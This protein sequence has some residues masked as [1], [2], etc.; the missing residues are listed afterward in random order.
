MSAAFEAAVTLLTRLLLL[1]LLV[2]LGV[3]V[4]DLRGREEA[5]MNLPTVTASPPAAR[6][7][8]RPSPSPSPVAP[9]PAPSVRSSE[10]TAVVQGAGPCAQTLTSTV[11]SWARKSH[12]TI[13]CS[14]S[15][16]EGISYSL[17]T[18]RLLVAPGFPL[19]VAT[20]ARFGWDRVPQAYRNNPE[21][22]CAQVKRTWSSFVATHAPEWDVLCSGEARALP[23]RINAPQD[24]RVAGEAVFKNKTIHLFQR[25]LTLAALEETLIHE[26]GHAEASRW[27]LR[28]RRSW[29]AR[30]GSPW[31]TG[32][33]ERQSSEVWA[34]SYSRY[35]LRRPGG[36]SLVK[37]LG[38]AAVEAQLRLTGA[39]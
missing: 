7:L 25:T 36:V 24:T 23:G 4:L 39:L 33:Y 13:A 18:R 27:T 32:P 1:A 3:M 28:Q 16:K 35:Y 26:V 17:E 21:L 2:T 10:A 31:A 29:G 19:E 8:T 14:S 5:A 37:P 30:V 20:N 22:S 11:P 9:K 6:A 38:A 34:E 12:W 15:L